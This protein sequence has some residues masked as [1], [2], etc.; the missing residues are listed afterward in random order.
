MEMNTLTL[1]I[2]KLGKRK[3]NLIEIQISDPIHDLKGLLEACVKSEVKKFNS[4][5]TT[6]NLITFLAPA[7]IKQQSNT[8]KVSFGDSENK[9]LADLE[10]SIAT[11][12]QGFQDGLFVVFNGEEEIKDLDQTITLDNTI[13]IT[14]LSCLLYTSPSPRDATLS[15]MPSSA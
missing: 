7:A 2:K 8:G 5:K 15:R 11:V 6:I 10:K 1:K 9:N 12:L 13:P 4:E 3:V 14:F